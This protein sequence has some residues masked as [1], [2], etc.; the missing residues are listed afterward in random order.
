M[1]TGSLEVGVVREEARQLS[2]AEVHVS[3]HDGPGL[4]V[5]DLGALVADLHVSHEGGQ[6][7]ALILIAEVD[8]LVDVPLH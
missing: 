8:H 4:L 1:P 5:V 2:L 3:G 6:G 7:L